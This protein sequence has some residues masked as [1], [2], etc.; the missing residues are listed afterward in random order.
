MG[1]ITPARCIKRKPDGASAAQLR[2]RRMMHHGLQRCTNPSGAKDL[3]WDANSGQLQVAPRSCRRAPVLRSARVQA[4]RPLS[5]YIPLVLT[6]CG[7]LSPLVHEIRCTKT[8][9]TVGRVKLPPSC[10]PCPHDRSAL[11]KACQHQLMYPRCQDLQCHLGAVP[12]S[13]AEGPSIWLGASRSC[14]PFRS[15]LCVRPVR[16]RAN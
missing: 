15:K 1:G 8:G 7:C 4:C 13:R 12:S 10:M 9:L 11:A 14:A 16:E 6:L 5:I 3:C 2:S